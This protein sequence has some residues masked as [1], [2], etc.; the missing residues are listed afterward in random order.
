MMA[1][2]DH[3]PPKEKAALAGGD[4]ETNQC[5]AHFTHDSKKLKWRRSLERALDAVL[6]AESGDLG[7]VERN[8]IEAATSMLDVAGEIRR[9]LRQ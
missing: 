9:E 6:E 7:I 2:K 3:P 1:A 4:L 8:L 5:R